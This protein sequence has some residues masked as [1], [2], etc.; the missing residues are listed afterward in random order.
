MS[1]RQSPFEALAKPVLW[2]VSRRMLDLGIGLS[3]KRFD[4][5]AKSGLIPPDA[6]LLDVGCGIGHYSTLTRDPYLGVDMSDEYIAYARQKHG[7]AHHEFRSVDIATV[8]REGHTFDVVM[9]VDFLHH[10]SD[11]LCREVLA[12]ERAMARR[13]LVVFEPVTEQTNRI[14]RWFIDNDRGEH[15]R[16]HDRVRALLDE[17]G[18]HVERDEELY[19]G[20]IRTFVFVARP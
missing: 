5:I 6:S 7:D 15:M 8:R 19:L 12:D 16:P 20:P 3:R 2:D 1:A 11:S 14:G 9:S 13:C 4:W 18:L 10:L 17:S